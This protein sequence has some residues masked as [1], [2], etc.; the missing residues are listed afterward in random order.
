MLSPVTIRTVT[1]ARLQVATA[2][3]TS[4]LTGSCTTIERLVTS[5]RSSLWTHS[6][7]HKRSV[8]GGTPIISWS[9]SPIHM[10]SLYV[11]FSCT[12][13]SVFGTDTVPLI[14]STCSHICNRHSLSRLL[15]KESVLNK[16]TILRSVSVQYVARTRQLL[17]CTQ[18]LELENKVNRPQ[19]Q[20]LH[21]AMIKHNYSWIW[22]AQQH[23]D[24]GPGGKYTKELQYKLV[25]W[26]I[27]RGERWKVEALWGTMANCMQ[28][29]VRG[30]KIWSCQDSHAF[31]HSPHF[32][33]HWFAVFSDLW[34]SFA[35][36]CEGA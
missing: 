30:M 17:A 4:F 10:A 12:L 16:G 19:L 8:R 2:S 6:S 33:H 25:K 14:Q 7:L 3:G 35:S 28:S 34:L 36:V 1:P 13:N 23:E 5:Q 15:C 32:I 22:K 18:G 26:Q 27:F 20:V 29:S 24:P 31:I 11:E 9:G 21:T